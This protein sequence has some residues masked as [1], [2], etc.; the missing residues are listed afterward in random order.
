[1]V[2]VARKWGVNL[3]SGSAGVSRQQTWAGFEERALV[4]AALTAVFALP[5]G[6]ALAWLLL[7]VINVSAFGWRLP[8]HLFPSQWA[9]LFALAVASAALAAAW[10]S[11][12]LMRLPPAALLKVFAN[13]R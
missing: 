8:M 2:F 6:L 12:R 1:M 13:E 7:S 4:L 11:W 10:P 3:N 9:W 5:V